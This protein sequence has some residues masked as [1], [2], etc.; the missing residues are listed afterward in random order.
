[1]IAGPELIIG[2]LLLAAGAVYLLRKME[3]LAA[4]GAAS[5]ALLLAVL[6]WR[7]PLDTRVQV[8]GRTIWLGKAV[9]WEG[10]SLQLGAATQ[11]L[12]TFLLITAAVV[13]ILAW[14]TYQG[15]TIYP[16]GLILVALWAAV[17][18]VHPLTLAPGAV[19]LAAIVSVFLI[20]A[21]KA[22]E[23]RGAWR[24]LLFPTLA[25]PLFLI[26]AWYID[27]APLNPDDQTPFKIAGWLLIA[28]FVLLLQPVPLHVA[29]P[30]IA[31]QAPPVVAAFLWIGGQTTV[32]FLLQRFIVTYPWL[33]A[34]V[35]SA[36][37]LLWLGVLTALLAGALSATQS[38]LGRYFGYAG[39]F[40][41][42]VLL[43]A[44]ALRGTAG[45]PTAIWLVLTRAFALLT[46]AA[47]TA[48]IRHH[49]E[50]DRLDRIGGAIS[51]LPMA[52]LAL[53]AGGFAL[54][55]LPLTAQ[56]ASRWALFQLLAETDSRWVLLLLIG[57]TGVV[58]GTVRAGR[59]CFGP[60][61][62]S[63]VEREPWGLAL[64]AFILVGLGVVI[65]LYPQLLTAPVAAV[66][67]PLSTLGP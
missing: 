3:G 15:R 60:L 43:V 24:Q 62:G 17:A 9:V 27:Q 30:A 48:L 53:I 34:A 51:R 2:F 4:L 52:V 31:G 61:S 28:G 41:Y 16:F 18:M 21:G 45:L 38:S 36:R 58:I 23:T 44:M 49:M 5:A 40:D 37:W 35:D 54:I 39:L 57:A 26:A 66:I 13:F 14:L 11:A 25:V 1:M 64:A 47:G 33:T 12:L 42:G 29:I 46:M 55:G 19:V 67:L 8:A 65:G 20:Q 32:L 6:L 10:V 59:A 50:S 56:F 22:G 63:P 7:L